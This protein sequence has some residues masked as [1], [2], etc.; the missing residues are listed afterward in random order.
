[1]LTSLEL[2]INGF[3]ALVIL[4]LAIAS[5]IGGSKAP[6]NTILT[7]Y[8]RAEPHLMLVSNVFLLSVCATA[9]AKLAQHFGYL[10]AGQAERLEPWLTIP[11]MVLLVVFLAMAVKAWLKVRRE[12]TAT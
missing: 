12:G 10:D 8:Y 4:P 2:L 3:V 5:L 1:M 6:E 9:I 11:L 7:K